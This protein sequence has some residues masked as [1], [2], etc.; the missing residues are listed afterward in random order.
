[1]ETTLLKVM[2]FLVKKPE[3]G[4]AELVDYYENHHVPLILSLAPAPPASA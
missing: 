1:M 2:A 4:F 3:I